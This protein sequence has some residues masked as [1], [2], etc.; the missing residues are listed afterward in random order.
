MTNR[1]RVGVAG[2]VDAAQAAQQLAADR[3]QVVRMVPQ[4]TL[5]LPEIGSN[6]STARTTACRPKRARAGYGIVVLLWRC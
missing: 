4:D 3:V 1:R 6:A 5:A 2:L